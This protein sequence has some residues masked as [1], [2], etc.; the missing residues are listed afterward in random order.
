MYSVIRV[1]QSGPG[2]PDYAALHPGYTLNNFAANNAKDAN[3][4]LNKKLFCV[5][6]VIRGYILHLILSSVYILKTHNII[7]TK[8]TPGLHF[9]QLE[10]DLANIFQAVFLT[11]G[12]IG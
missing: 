2:L 8:I 1:F 9:D 3:R 4:G 12:N 7:F 6:C 10:G 11:Q 5:L